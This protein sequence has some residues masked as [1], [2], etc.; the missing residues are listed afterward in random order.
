MS[1]GCPIC[2]TETNT[3]RDG[4]PYWVCPSCACWFQDPAPPKVWHGPHEPPPLEMGDEDRAINRT[5][6]GNLF[7][8]YLGSRKG[9]R[10]LDIGAA[11][12]VL[13]SAFHDLGC[14]A[15]AIDGQPANDPALPVKTEQIDFET[16]APWLD[17]SGTF[18]LVTMI[19]VFEHCY[20]PRA[21]LRK[22]RALVADDGLVF[23][24]LPDHDVQGYERD[25]TPGHYQIHPF[26]HCLDSIC[27]AL[28]R[29][30]TFTIR[31]TYGLPPAGQRDIFLR[32]IK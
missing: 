1:A 4:S 25:L 24:R 30:Q 22:L 20:D 17:F 5:L 14:E 3:K 21:A 10:T 16:G 12:P 19:H 2:L 11:M 13:A 23:L 18:D 32:P 7:T 15:F 6:A 29:T 26:Y 28:V 8:N 27:E 9:A 31:E